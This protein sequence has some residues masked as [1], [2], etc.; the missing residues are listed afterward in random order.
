MMHKHIR[1]HSYFCI[2]TYKQKK[3]QCNDIILR[4]QM[5]SF[6]E[7]LDAKIYERKRKP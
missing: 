5:I 6:E 7:T 1:Q 3:D 2:K 4:K